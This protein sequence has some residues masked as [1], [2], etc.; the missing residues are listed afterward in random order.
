[1]AENVGQVS[2]FSQPLKIPEAMCESSCNSISHISTF[3]LESIVLWCVAEAYGHCLSSHK[4]EN[5]RDCRR[6]LL[7]KL[8]AGTAEYRTVFRPTGFFFTA[9]GSLCI[10]QWADAT[11]GATASH[12]PVMTPLGLLLPISA[13]SH[14]FWTNQYR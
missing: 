13:Q 8:T 5:K 10:L 12:T 11:S 2:P 4:T 3:P 1:M 6:R 9:S 14:T 7:M